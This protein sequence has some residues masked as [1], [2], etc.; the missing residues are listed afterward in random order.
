MR[1]LAIS[2]LMAAAAVAVVSATAHAGSADDD[3]GSPGPV[4][5]LQVS[6]LFDHIVVDSIEDAIEASAAD[7]AQALIL[8]VNSR[9]AVVGDDEME[10]LLALVSEA[11]LPVA[12]WVGPSGARLYGSPAQLLAR[13]RRH[14]DGAGREGRAHRAN[15]SMRR[16][17]R[18]TSATRR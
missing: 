3:D 1:R 13:R 11:P 4:D 10:R 15:C 14:R 16:R 8:Q 7:G 5:V 6:G 9:G 12:V 18:S 17:S 2:L